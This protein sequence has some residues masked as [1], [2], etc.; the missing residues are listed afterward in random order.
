[1]L[2]AG[3]GAQLRRPWSRPRLAVGLEREPLKCGTFLVGPVLER[4]CDLLAKHLLAA[5]SVTSRVHESAFPGSEGRSS[6]P[7]RPIC[8]LDLTDT[9]VGCQD[10]GEK[11]V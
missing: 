8:R 1:M 9:I 2:R 4:S 10:H 6:L 7:L 11:D 5:A 3:D